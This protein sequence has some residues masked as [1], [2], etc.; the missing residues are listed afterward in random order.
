MKSR[1]RADQRK[2]HLC[3][4]H[5]LLF[6]WVTWGELA[7][8]DNA[9]EPSMQPRV[10]ALEKARLC[11][12]CWSR[13]DAPHAAA[14]DEVGR[15]GL[16]TITARSDALPLTHTRP[17]W[18]GGRVRF[19]LPASSCALAVA[20]AAVLGLI[21]WA[22]GV[23][24]PQ[25]ATTAR[26]RSDVRAEQVREVD[27]YD[28]R[29]GECVARPIPGG[30]IS[31]VQVGPC[32]RPHREQIYAVFNLARG[33]YAGQKTVDRRG[34]A[35]CR[36]R[37]RTY[38]GIDYDSSGLGYFA[39]TPYVSDLSEDREVVCVVVDSEQHRGTLEGARR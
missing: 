32:N 7:G 19:G 6:A 11:P 16:R 34:D 22:N 23:N 20:V 14:A 33:H 12:N 1:S 8:L 9:R 18:G 31:T 26:A 28:L 2:D 38:V 3:L 35:A 15:G 25:T 29:E 37:F 30:D 39:V 5:W 17:G 36:K 21:G 27:F 24:A 10:D 4:T 13:G